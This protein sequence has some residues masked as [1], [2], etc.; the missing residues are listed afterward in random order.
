MSIFDGKKVLA[1]GAHPDDI[2]LHCAG[3]FLRYKPELYAVV[4]TKGGRR[5]GDRVSEQQEASTRLGVKKLFH[6]DFIDCYMRFDND[7]VSY[8]DKI[9][10]EVKPDIVV[11]HEADDFHQDHVVVAHSVVA[12][13]RH[14]QVSLLTYPETG[15]V[16]PP[17]REGLLKIDIKDQLEEKNK[18]LDIFE[19]QKDRLYFQIHRLAEIECFNICKLLL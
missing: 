13:L 3:T 12:S 14:K 4:M 9:I 10:E 11:T 6:A 2:E 7:T 16:V 18:V 17:H 19:T 5:K 15:L 1:I 8:L